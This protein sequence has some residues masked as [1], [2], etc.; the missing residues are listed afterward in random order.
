MEHRMS[1]ETFKSTICHQVKDNGDINFLIDTLESDQIRTLF[2]Q[3][4]YAEALYLLAMV[5]YLSR[6]NDVPLCTNYD[7]IRA[8]KLHE[9]IFPSDIIIAAAVMENDQIKQDSIEAAISEFMRFN[10]VEC[11]VRNTI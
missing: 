11:D 2:Q 7:D 3:K 4:W 9:P 8:S 1:F 6:E 10:I 5:D